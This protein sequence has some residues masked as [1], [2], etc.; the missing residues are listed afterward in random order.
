MPRVQVLLDDGT[1]STITDAQGHFS[2]DQLAPGKHVVHLRGDTVAPLDVNENIVAGKQRQVRYYVVAR[3]RYSTT[4]RATAAVQ[5]TVEQK[6]SAEEIKRIPG[7]QGDTLRA[8]QNFAGVARAPFGS[9]Q[10]VV[11]GSRP[12]DTRIYVDGVYIPTL[13]HFGALRSTVNSEM[14]SSLSFM[15]GGYGVDYGRG[16]GGVVEIESRRP[17][18]TGIHGFVQIDLMD[19]S[20]SLDAAVSKNV[21]LAFALRRSW[22][23]VFLPLFTSNDLQLSP[24][25]YDYQ[26][27]LYWRASKQDDVDVFFFGSDDSL[28]VLARGASPEAAANIN[29]HTFY[30]RGLLRW[31]RRLP[32]RATFQLTGSVGYDQPFEFHAKFG[33]LP[34][35]I[36]AATVEYNLRA[37][38][39]VPLG[40][41]LRVDAGLDFEGN[42]YDIKLAAPSF[43][44]IFQGD[45]SQGSN[46][47]LSSYL[48]DQSTLYLHGIAPYL[49]LNFT[50]LD[51]RLTITPAFRLEIFSIVGYRGK[52]GAFD[53]VYVRPEPRV[54]LRYQIKPW[55]AIKASLGLYHQLPDPSAF[56]RQFGNPKVLPQMAV[57]YVAG[58]EFK[59]TSTLNID[60]EGFYKDLRNLVVGS[61]VAGGP[62]LVSDGIGRVYGGE[63]T[64]RQ[65]LWKNFF[66]WACYTLSR[67]ERKEHADIPWHLYEYDQTHILT[68]V[69]SYKLP[70]GYQIGLRF[71][72]VT[73]NLNTPVAASYAD[74][75]SGRYV[76]INGAPNSERLSDFHQLDLRFDKTWTFN[77][78]RFSLYLDIQNLYNAKNPE[79]LAYNY[80]YMQ[81][82]PIVGLPFYP[83][84]GLRGD[85]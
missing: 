5:Q 76:A 17:Q 18:P 37:I 31:L 61:E 53:E 51:R 73:G 68:L 80:N 67:S 44:A 84:L 14:V 35:N 75:N 57:H 2:M 71:R 54:A 25:Y 22:I 65:E 60:I 74:L 21:Q 40:S 43:G 83:S 12:Y 42:R 3:S 20:L 33:N 9:G 41:L 56:M 28:S 58:F 78:W 45:D 81:S 49:A 66:G 69:A 72:Y 26:A 55:M 85:F 62:P 32:G 52:P 39:R 47:F 77:R 10:L 23:D 15:P 16:M 48:T 6:V 46:S 29:S 4:V 70:R 1:L 36:D 34:I 24:V 19:G 59:P 7:T 27:R 11:W 50:L 13:F 64:V 63:I 82:K 8:V 38:G 30:H 79:F